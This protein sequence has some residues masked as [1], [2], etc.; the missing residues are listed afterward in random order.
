M[1]RP[2]PAYFPFFSFHV[3]I[4][5]YKKPFF[6][7][8]QVQERVESFF[9]DICKLCVD[10]RTEDEK[11]HPPGKIKRRHGGSL[12]RN[13][14]PNKRL[15]ISRRSQSFCG[16]GN[17]QNFIN[18]IDM[19]SDFENEDSDIN[20]NNFNFCKP[21]SYLIDK[22]D[23]L[24]KII[25]HYNYREY[26]PSGSDDS[27]ISS[28][29]KSTSSSDNSL[30]SDGEEFSPNESDS[31]STLTQ[32]ESDTE[33]KQDM[34]VKDTLSNSLMLSASSDNESILEQK[35]TE[36]RLYPECPN[37]S[38]SPTMPHRL[39][40]I[41]SISSGRNSSFDDLESVPT[42]VADILIVSHGGYIKETMRYFVER[43]D[44][45]IPGMKGHAYKVCPNCS[46]SKFVI[47]LDH[48]GNPS[49]TCITIHDRD[50]LISLD[51]TDAKGAF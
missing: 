43:L 9:K 39:S 3:H 51:I 33:S 14:G 18:E 30:T 16:S 49:L 48:S 47:S 15:E 29:L 12:G 26:V 44:C 23:N 7:F 45:K 8:F 5:E 21:D 2:N 42:N 13:S 11:P 50:H 22:S 46:V 32:T 19:I 35:G 38:L 1:F 4:L 24:D 31:V 37:V 40:S 10:Y 41:S 6:P 36:S 34:N 27:N 28:D 25:D 17:I 20:D